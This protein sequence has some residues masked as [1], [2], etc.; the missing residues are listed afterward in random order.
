MPHGIKGAWLWPRRAP[1]LYWPMEI[2]MDDEYEDCATC[3]SCQDDIADYE[4]D[5]CVYCDPEQFE[6]EGEMK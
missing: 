6:T 1:S 5:Y 4:G 3:M 2:D